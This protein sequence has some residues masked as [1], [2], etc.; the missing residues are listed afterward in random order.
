[1][2]MYVYGWMCAS[3]G[4]ERLDGY[5][6]SYSVFM[7]SSVPGECE[8]TSSENKVPS[9][10]SQTTMSLGILMKLKQFM[11]MISQMKPQQVETSGK[12]RCPHEGTKLK[13]T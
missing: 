7:S 10:V 12:E 9:Q 11:E 4:P 13:L 2:C 1:V 3:L 8:H 5:Y 6:Y